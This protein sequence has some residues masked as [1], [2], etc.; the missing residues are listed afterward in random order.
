MK[1]RNKAPKK[2]DITYRILRT[3]VPEGASGA[4]R[5]YEYICVENTLHATIIRWEWDLKLDK[6]EDITPCDCVEHV[7][8]PE[9]ARLLDSHRRRHPG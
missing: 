1:I 2:H 8:F 9:L 4:G 6:I 5:R 3:S 7:V